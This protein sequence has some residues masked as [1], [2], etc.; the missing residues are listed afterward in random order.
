MYL[1]S[2]IEQIRDNEWKLNNSHINVFLWLKDQIL[3]SRKLAPG[4][5]H[6][7]ALHLSDTLTGR[8]VIAICEA[9]AK[10]QL[11]YDSWA[12]NSTFN[13]LFV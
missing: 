2:L 5:S 7:N 10:G 8:E 11:Y 4:V 9:A 12:R 3:H 13:N 6:K 1:P